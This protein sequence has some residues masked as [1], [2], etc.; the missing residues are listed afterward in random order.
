LIHEKIMR[1]GCEKNE[2][3]KGQI[4]EEGTHKVSPYEP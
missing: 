1:G 3:E 2:Y 4:I